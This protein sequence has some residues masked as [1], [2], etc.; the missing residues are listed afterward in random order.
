MDV[1]GEKGWSKEE[2]IAW[3]SS[4]SPMKIGVKI[5]FRVLFKKGRLTIGLWCSCEIICG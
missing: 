2:S 3:V 5:V 4:T 1:M